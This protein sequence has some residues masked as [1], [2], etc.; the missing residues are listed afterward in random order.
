MSDFYII[1]VIILNVC[2][3]TVMITLFNSEP[4]RKLLL[5]VQN[6]DTDFQ[7]WRLITGNQ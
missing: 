4:D 1:I 5:N 2:D 7:N 6:K 3:F